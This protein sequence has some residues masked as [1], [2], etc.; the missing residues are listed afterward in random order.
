MIVIGAGLAGLAAAAMAAHAGGPDLRVLV[1][2]G[3]QPGGRGRTTVTPEGFRL[4]QGAHALYRGAGREVL[5]RLGVH[6]TGGP[7]STDSYGLAGDR[8]LPLPGNAWKLVRSPWLGLRAKAQL[9]RVLGTL[10][11]LR[12][13][14]HVHQSAAAWIAGLEMKADAEAVNQQ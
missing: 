7:P 2:D 13:E 14:R 10:P 12:P 1:I 5:S 11:L 3:H 6:P 9:A 4:N 8:L